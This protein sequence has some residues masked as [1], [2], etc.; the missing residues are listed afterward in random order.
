MEI[1]KIYNDNQT[2]ANETKNTFLETYKCV[3]LYRDGKNKI[4]KY[5]KF[6][7]LVSVNSN[8]IFSISKNTIL[9]AFHDTKSH[10]SLNIRNV[11]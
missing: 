6:E 7:N 4:K 9:I 2:N 8:S 5:I 11:H 3:F 10:L 1:S